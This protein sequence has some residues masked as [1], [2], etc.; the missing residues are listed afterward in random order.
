MHNS[1]VEGQVDPAVAATHC[2][3]S[4]SALLDDWLSECGQACALFLDVDGTLLDIAD[5]PDAVRVPQVLPAALKVLHRRL[6]G[7]LALVSGRSVDNL[8]CL[9]P[10][11][12][13]PASGGHGAHWRV[14]AD[15]PLCHET[16]TV[17]SSTLREKL[18]ALACSQPGVICEDKGSSVAMHYRRVPAAGE[19][20]AAALR[21]LLDEPGNR[22]LRLLPGK[23]VFE[24]VAHSGDKSQAIRRFLEFAPF[25]GR[26]PLFIGDDVTDEAALALMPALGGLGLSVGKLLPG[27]SA[28]FADAAEVRS[29]LIKAAGGLQR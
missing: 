23:M 21:D 18:M 4:A 16:T 17:L 29:A 11:M 13:L 19:T 3:A 12:R 25:A 26:R 20:L 22:G 7:A 14:R 6:D 27:A 1:M 8:D 10:P 2:D 9:F 15:A 24:V 5:T 28:A